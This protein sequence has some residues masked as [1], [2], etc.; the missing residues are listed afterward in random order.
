MTFAGSGG[1][2]VLDNLFAFKAAIGDF[3]ATNTIDLGGFAYASGAT[4][5]YS[6]A[7]GMLT[8]SGGGKT[9]TLAL[10][11]GSYVTSNFALGK[12]GTGGTL[13]T[14]TS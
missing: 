2:L 5:S 6:A 7:T 8:L 4:A 9:A 13:V 3:A 1:V 14:Y 10:A 12:D 11:G